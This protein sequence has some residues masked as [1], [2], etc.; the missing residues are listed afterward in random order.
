MRL[1]YN[2]KSRIL[3]HRRHRLLE[4]ERRDRCPLGSPEVGYR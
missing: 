1:D 4:E 3:R 2:K